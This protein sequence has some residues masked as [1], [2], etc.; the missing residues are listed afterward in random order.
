MTM[1]I[2][3]RINNALSLLLITCFIHFQSSTSFQASSRFFSKKKKLLPYNVNVN[4]NFNVNGGTDGKGTGRDIC[5]DNDRRYG[6]AAKLSLLMSS[7][8]T[9][10]E[11]VSSS[12]S[13]SFSCNQ[14]T[15]PTP[16]DD[17]ELDYR[18]ALSRLLAGW[19]ET[20]DTKNDK[21]S[22]DDSQGQTTVAFLFVSRHWAPHLHRIVRKAQ[23]MLGSRTQLLTVVGGGV[24]GGGQELQESC[25]MS[26][27]GGMLPSG[28]SVSLFSVTSDSD[29]DVDEEEISRASS[30]SIPST[31]TTS[32]PPSSCHNEDHPS[33]RELSHL[34][35]ADPLCDKVECVLDQLKHGIVAGGIS[36]PG[37]GNDKASLAI[38]DRVLPPGSLVGATFKGNFGLQV[39]VSKGYHPIGPVYRVTSVNGPVIQELD[40]EPALKQLEMTMNQACDRDQA[41]VRRD[42]G[43]LGGIGRTDVGGY[44]D[45]NRFRNEDEDTN[46]NFGSNPDNLTLRQV[47]G[48]RPRSGSI[49]V[50]GPQIREGDLFRFHVRSPDT[51]LKD[52][53]FV[54]DRVHT[55][56]MF[57]GQQRGRAIGALQIS[58]LGRGQ[59]MFGEDQTNVDYRHVKELLLRQGNAAITKTSSSD[60]DD[61]DD[62]SYVDTTKTDDNGTSPP[63]AGLFANAEIGPGGFQMGA[64]D[65][66]SKS[67][68]HGFSTVVAMFCDY[69]QSKSSSSTSSSATLSQATFLHCREAWE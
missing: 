2:H 35:F 3:R 57:L 66:D 46:A 26:F 29:S 69:S 61:D 54:L 60:D 10:E 25:S 9:V 36:I 24:I 37:Q 15:I 6:S 63:I 42:G 40:S 7:I 14:V 12:W 27:M 68:L 59:K 45:E 67:Y 48:F 49:L 23:K 65:V 20:I 17:D 56:R 33:N 53:K 4:L 19:D 13:S 38:G 47:T 16:N 43:L 30:S 39:V 64:L 21:P 58:C 18:S 51:A 62:D 55:E 50:C 32:S 52:W 31:T 8:A 22:R 1:M 44:G 28:S 41:L 5:N 34:V 11:Q